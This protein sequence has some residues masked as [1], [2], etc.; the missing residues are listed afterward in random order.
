MATVEPYLLEEKVLKAIFKRTD[1][2][3]DAYDVIREEM[4]TVKDYAYIYK[5]MLEVYKTN[6]EVNN[7]NVKMWLE[8]NNVYITNIDIVDKLYNESY[9]SINIKSTFIK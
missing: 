1:A 6:D 7:E 5:A 2:I 9:T 8:D 3:I 4:F